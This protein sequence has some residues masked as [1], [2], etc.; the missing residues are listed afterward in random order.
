MLNECEDHSID[1]YLK[2]LAA[3]NGTQ[4]PPKPA[5]FDLNE[6]DLV[7]RLLAPRLAFE[8]LLLPL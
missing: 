3:V 4:V 6:L 8:K 7:C 2:N 5:F 1:I